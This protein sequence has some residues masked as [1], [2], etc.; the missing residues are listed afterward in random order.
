M[1]QKK[2]DLKSSALRDR[3][4]ETA[5]KRARKRQRQRHKALEGHR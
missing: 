3:N 5:T 1:W 2:L 4:R